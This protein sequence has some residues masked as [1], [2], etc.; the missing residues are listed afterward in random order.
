MYTDQLKKF[1]HHFSHILTIFNDFSKWIAL[2]VLQNVQQSVQGTHYV[3]YKYLGNLLVLRY[4]VYTRPHP[5]LYPVT[6]VLAAGQGAGP[7][8]AGNNNRTRNKHI[9]LNKISFIKSY[10]PLFRPST[11]MLCQCGCSVSAVFFRRITTQKCTTASS[12]LH[13]TY[14][15]HTTGCSIWK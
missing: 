2:K 5:I 3:L 13:I 11:L 9:T 15:V 6:V 10:L 4:L 14:N 1:F 12:D 8:A 7:G